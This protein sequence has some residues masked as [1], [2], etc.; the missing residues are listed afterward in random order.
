[1]RGDGG[2]LVGGR[3]VKRFSLATDGRKLD[4]VLLGIGLDVDADLGA[5]GA[6]GVQFPETEVVL[7]HDVS[8]I[9]RDAKK[10]QIAVAVMSNIYAVIRKVVGKA[11]RPFPGCNLR[12]SQNVRPTIGGRL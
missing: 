8:A 1:M 9:G 5:L 10:K 2:A 6:R 3:K 12:F 4:V 7:V 11:D